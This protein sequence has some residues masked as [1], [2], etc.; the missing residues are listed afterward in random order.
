MLNFYKAAVVW[1]RPLWTPGKISV[2]F[3]RDEKNYYQTK[4]NLDKAMNLKKNLKA[5]LILKNEV[6]LIL[7]L[8]SLKTLIFL[9]HYLILTEIF[10]L[11][12]ID[13]NALPALTHLVL[14]MT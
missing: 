5:K 12:C 8:Y 2:K 14:V 1:V 3:L 11:V 9:L 7:S 13:L 4:Y 10:L 6:K